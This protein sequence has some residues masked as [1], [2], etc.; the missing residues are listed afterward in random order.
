[1]TAS[2]N[3]HGGVGDSAP[4]N[5][6]HGTRESNNSSTV[7]HRKGP[8][9]STPVP[10]KRSAL[11]Q[12]N[13]RPDLAE[14]NLKFWLAL[15]VVGVATGI[16]GDLMMVVLFG[17]QHIAYNYHT[18]SFQRAVEHVSGLHRVVAL[19]IAGVFGG[20]AWYLLRKFTK[21]ESTE[22]DNILWLG[23]GQLSFRRSFLTS[24]ISEIVIG[25]GASIGREAAP[26]L[27][28]AV[29]GDYVA[30]WTKLTPHQRRLL[31]ACGA[32][33]GLA[34]VYNVPLGGALFAAE[35][36]YGS[37]SISVVLPALATSVI[38]TVTAWI[39]L[40]NHATYLGLANFHFETSQLVWAVVVGPIFGVLSVAYVRMMAW[41][42]HYRMGGKKIIA[43][44]FIAFTI[45]GI[46]GVR[47]PQLFGNG[48]DM[49]HTVFL[50]GGTLTLLLALFALKPLVTALCVG[51]GASGGLFTPTL[52]TGA[53]LGGALGLIWS[54]FWPGASTGSYALI[55]AAAIMGSG[56]QAPFA[57]IVLVLE[58]THTGFGIIVP[59]MVATILA[60]LVAKTIDGY[61]IYSA[62]LP[63][64]EY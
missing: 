53:V 62:R 3:L 2:E 42:S 4:D 50:G 63:E 56:M 30:R 19:M 32:G 15:V 16:F 29:S 60:T 33:A 22:A 34:A 8:L 35:L 45:L 23:K 7:R 47:Y 9:I 51:S 44:P 41:V 6:T 55:G 57:A 14:P 26:K 43:A 5:N 25:L 54:M 11:E 20:V 52:S 37:L 31:I 13:T 39:Y 36:L 21:G 49:A 40:P 61:S 27:M 58:L 24:I 10:S 38:A 59:L 18:G 48:K 28:G 12:P 17:V 1:M 64:I 46:I